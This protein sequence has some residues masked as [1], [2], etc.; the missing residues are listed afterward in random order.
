MHQ[1]VKSNLSIELFDQRYLHLIGFFAKKQAKSEVNEPIYG[2]QRDPDTYNANDIESRKQK[3]EL[4]KKRVLKGKLS[5]VD[6][7]SEVVSTMPQYPGW[8]ERLASNSEAFVKAD[9]S[10]GDTVEEMQ[11]ETIEILNKEKNLEGSSE[12]RK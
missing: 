7:D 8:D 9:R 12:L 11:K 5:G 6:A 1:Q 2:T 10:E 4:E 3:I